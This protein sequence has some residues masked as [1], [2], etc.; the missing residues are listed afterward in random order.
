LIFSAYKAAAMI[1]NEIDA[2]VGE[3][4][5]KFQSTGSQ[6]ER[7]IS[8]SDTEWER[9]CSSDP[10]FGEYRCF[11]YYC[12]LIKSGTGRPRGL[13]LHFDMVR[14]VS[15]SSSGWEHADESLLVIAYAHERDTWW[16]PRELL[17]TDAGRLE[18]ETY[19]TTAYG[20]AENKILVWDTDSQNDWS[21]RDWLFALP[22]RVLN[23]PKAVDEQLIGPIMQLL[24]GQIPKISLKNWHAVKW[25]LKNKSNLQINSF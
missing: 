6:N 3:F 15:E 25:P 23:G 16:I 4:V 18:C 20:A 17:V 19:W 9:K 12:D 2:L 14:Q 13:T 1:D 7:K 11:A 5:S 10:H 24:W 22:L 21:K 8:I